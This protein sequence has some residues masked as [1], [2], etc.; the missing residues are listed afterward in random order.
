MNKFFYI[1]IRS[2][3]KTKEKIYIEN[4]LKST[5]KLSLKIKISTFDLA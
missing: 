3:L 1:F 4:I 2:D 5:I